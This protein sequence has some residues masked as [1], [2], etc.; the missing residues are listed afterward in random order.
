[1]ENYGASHQQATRNVLNEM[2]VDQE[3]ASIERVQNPLIKQQ[4]PPT[5]DNATEAPTEYPWIDPPG[6]KPGT[7][8][9]DQQW[10]EKRAAETKQRRLD[11]L[12]KANQAKAENARKRKEAEQAY[13]TQLKQQ[14][15]LEKLAMEEQ[16]LK[17]S[18]KEKELTSRVEKLKSTTI[19]TQP[20]SVKKNKTPFS[21]AQKDWKASI[22]QL[23]KAQEYQQQIARMEQQASQ[24][25]A[26]AKQP[27]P[28]EAPKPKTRE[29][30]NPFEM[31][32]EAQFDRFC[33]QYLAN[34]QAAQANSRPRKSHTRQVYEEEDDVEMDDWVGE[35]EVLP[36]RKPP[37]SKSRRSAVLHRQTGQ[38][39]KREVLPYDMY[40]G[41]YEDEEQHG[42]VPA[43][44]H[45]FKSPQAVAK[46]F[47][48]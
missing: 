17:A 22:Q 4:P 34:E 12:K 41:G 8:E 30:K 15:R 43:Q 3:E 9:Y 37:Q 38:R 27:P 1:M 13:H 11:A 14:A 18:Q 48:F 10:K 33:H 16:Q 25:L 5:M 46:S 24:K 39:R 23:S 44:V 26:K 45:Q 42:F 28:Q 2:V 31:M 21:T 32:S 35:E 40:T 19:T 36:Q 29:V 20:T 47:G 6:A 7:F